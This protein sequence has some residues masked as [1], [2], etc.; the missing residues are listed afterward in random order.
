M[1][2]NIF[3]PLMLHFRRLKLGEASE[4][5][6]FRTTRKGTGIMAPALFNFL[7]RNLLIAKTRHPG[8]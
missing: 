7:H 8:H 3:Q 1:R 5:L 4:G 2:F 6:Q